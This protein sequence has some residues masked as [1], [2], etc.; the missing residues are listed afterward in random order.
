MLLSH[1]RHGLAAVL[2]LAAADPAP[3]PRPPELIGIPTIYVTRQ[4][5]TLLDIARAYDLGYVEVRAAN[6]GIDPWLPGAGK[7]LT[8]PTQNGLPDS[9]RRGIVINLAELRLYYFPVAGDPLSFPIGIGREGW[10]TPVG[11]TRVAKKRVHP[12]WVP[13]ASE[14]EEN[15]ELPASVGPGPD[16]PMGD[17]ALYLGWVGY[18][19]HGTNRPY[20]VGRR[21]SHG[22]IR[23]YPEDIEI[24]FH[25]VAAG[26]PVTVVDQP[27][28]VGWSAGEL[29][30]EVHPTQADADA[31]EKKGAPRSSIAID[32]DALVLKA[33]G[34]DAGRLDWYTIHLAETRRSGVPVQVTRPVPY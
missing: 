1:L 12:V 34:L 30:L 4:S 15:P 32:A 26:T 29:Y 16:N 6:P 3:A 7:V 24:L 2:L 10:E 18:A 14:H 21:G 17:Y 8:L 31:L 27:A 20:S 11:R 25:A 33:A 5:D 22:C 13:T 19:V 28:K 9:P 23:L